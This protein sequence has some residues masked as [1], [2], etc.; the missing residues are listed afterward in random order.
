MSKAQKNAA[1]K[2]RAAQIQIQA[3]INPTTEPELAQSWD[4]LR[5]QFDGSSKKALAWAVANARNSMDTFHVWKD[6]EEDSRLEIKAVSMAAALD[7]AA[8]QYGYIDY[9]DMAQELGWSGNEG[10]NVE[11]LDTER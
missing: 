3:L 1:A 11:T 6:G 4:Y 2:Y 9:A 7:I 10:L 5:R 8:R